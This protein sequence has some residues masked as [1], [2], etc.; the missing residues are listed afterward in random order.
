MSIQEVLLL[1][2]ADIEGSACVAGMT[3]E[4]DPITG[5]RWVRFVHGEGHNPA[6]SRSGPAGRDVQPF[7][8]V[9]VDLLTPCPQPPYAE[10]CLTGCAEG[11]FQ[12]ARSVTG[13]QRAAF[14][15][16]YRDRAPEQVLQY[17][18]RSLCLIQPEWIHGTFRLH[19]ESDRLA[20]HMAFGA[21]RRSYRG[22][23]ARGGL[24][25]FDRLWQSVG[26]SWLRPGSE[27]IDFDAGDLTARFGM[28]AIYLTLGLYRQDRGH[29]L[30]ILGVHPVPALER[31]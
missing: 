2:V 16:K 8:V 28:T 13:Q 14:L 9:T 5:L 24:P 1:A 6:H 25:V 30:S 22:S 17:Q 29:N 3:A 20:A 7:D 18:E 21:N 31:S 4:P 11:P 15:H 19:P 12:V 10:N 23:Y 27:W 26:R